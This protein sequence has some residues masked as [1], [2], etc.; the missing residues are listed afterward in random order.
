MTL[1][2]FVFTKY[3]KVKV[4]SNTVFGTGSVKKR[5]RV[6]DPLLIPVCTHMLGVYRY[7]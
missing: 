7:Y 6:G 5:I 1:K 4:P 2:T 3:Y